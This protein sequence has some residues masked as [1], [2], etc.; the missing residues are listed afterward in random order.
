MIEH[1]AR[2]G[3]DGVVTRNPRKNDPV[4]NYMLSQLA[5]R[6]RGM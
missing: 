6:A 4:A 1:R 2:R 3:G 5:A